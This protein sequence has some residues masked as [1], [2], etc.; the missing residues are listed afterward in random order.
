MSVSVH[1]CEFSCVKSV[2]QM[3]GHCQR[4]VLECLKMFFCIFVFKKCVKKQTVMCPVTLH[5]VFV[6][7]WQSINPKMP[8]GL[9]L[10]LLQLEG[11]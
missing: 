11:H 2:T 3:M 9:F 8:F 6:Q 5:V 1:A 4:L 7:L 10:F